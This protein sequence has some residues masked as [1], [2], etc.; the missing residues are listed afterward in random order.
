[1]GHFR[2]YD[3][4]KDCKNNKTSGWGFGFR[5]E[6]G[7]L[8]PDDPEYGLTTSLKCRGYEPKDEIDNG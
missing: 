7:C 4:C 6:G 8:F 5:K 3:T 2:L 1:M